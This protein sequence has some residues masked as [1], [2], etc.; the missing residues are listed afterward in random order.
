M[1]A[2]FQTIADMGPLGLVGLAIFV[3]I[4]IGVVKAAG[5]KNNSPNYKGKDSSG[6]SGS[7]NNTPTPPPAA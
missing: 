3:L 6:S 4:C 2:L 5:S 1:E 7:S